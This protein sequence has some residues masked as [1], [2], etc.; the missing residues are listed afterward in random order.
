MGNAKT[1]IKFINSNFM[2]KMAAKTATTSILKCVL[3]ARINSVQVNRVY[4]MI[5]SLDKADTMSF[6]DVFSCNL[7]AI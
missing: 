4:R 3:Y 1:G 6:T 5:R 2:Y 7:A